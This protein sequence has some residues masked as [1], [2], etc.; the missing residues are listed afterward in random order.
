M[1]CLTKLENIIKSNQIRDFIIH[2]EYTKNEKNNLDILILNIK[3]SSEFIE[4]EENIYFNEKNL[5]IDGDEI[6]KLKQIIQTQSN[7]MKK[8]IEILENIESKQYNILITKDYSGMKPE[9]SKKL[10]KKL[11]SIEITSD[12]I[13]HVHLHFKYLFQN[14]HK[15]YDM[16]YYYT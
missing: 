13:H 4:F 2:I 7:N 9:K 14:L 16:C 12:Q 11:C 8:K 6:I 3:Y 10:P 1:I 5:I 15:T